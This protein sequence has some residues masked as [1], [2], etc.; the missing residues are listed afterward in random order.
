M[1]LSFD[2]R[3]DSS[4]SRSAKRASSRRATQGTS[5]SASRGKSNASSSRRSASTGTRSGARSGARSAARSSSRSNAKEHAVTAPSTGGTRRKSI[6]DKDRAK[7]E[8]AEGRASR[9]ARGGKGDA[10]K[11]LAVEGKPARSSRRRLKD[12]ADQGTTRPKRSTHISHADERKSVST[13][14]RSKGSRKSIK[15]TGASVSIED[16]SVSDDT[17]RKR[18]AAV[19]DVAQGRGRRVGDIRAAE[20]AKRNRQR[21]R[22]YVLK[23]FGVIALVL[24]VIFGSIF[25]YRSDVLAVNNVK[26]N[27]V[28][29]LTDQEVTQLAAVPDDSTLLRLDSDGIANRLK[30]HPWVQSVNVVRKFPDTVELDVTE[31]DVAAV[32]KISNKSIWVISTD[33][34]WLSAATK[35]DWKSYRRIIGVD[36]SLAAPVAGS[37]CTDGGILNALSI[38]DKISD[39][40]AS[41]VKSI[42]AE[43]SVKTSLTLKNGVTVAF[44]DAS[45]IELKEADINALLQQY[46][47]KI[48]Y[49]NVRVPSRPT[50]R[51]SE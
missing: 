50:Y 26:V 40:L 25:L 38:Y 41:Q 30:E 7:A 43:S 51:G 6:K 35:Q 24:F 22:S 16:V 47:G 8:K 20:R 10:A 23:I 14:S 27:G 33:G 45:D 4:G 46:D 44:G 2:P 1:G 42:S 15:A 13:G 29:H 17:R 11:E 19:D 49:I 31:R 34:V 32:V 9:R 3:L 48:S 21:Y 18:N 28:S 39:D 12:A 36:A 5:P 37:E